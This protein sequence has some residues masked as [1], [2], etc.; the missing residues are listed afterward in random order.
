MDTRKLSMEP[1]GIT[2]QE[3]NWAPLLIQVA[4]LVCS[5]VFILFS[6]NF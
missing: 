5:Y 6:V 3:E 4:C 1:S 2:E